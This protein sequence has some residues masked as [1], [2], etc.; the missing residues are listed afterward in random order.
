MGSGKHTATPAKAA[1]A[2]AS[3]D[4]RARGVVQ[5][6]LPERGFGF[7]R[8][9]EGKHDD[10]G[11]DFFFHIS[12]LAD[13]RIEDLEIGALVTFEPRDVAKGRRAEHIERS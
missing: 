2:A 8:C 13:C 3:T 6:L 9:T 7:I 12:G 1:T 4:G 5:R 10:L 11:Q